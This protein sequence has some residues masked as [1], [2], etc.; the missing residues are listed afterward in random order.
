[1]EGDAGEGAGNDGDGEDDEGDES[2]SEEGDDIVMSGDSADSPGNACCNCAVCRA[3][4]SSGVRRRKY[5]APLSQAW[6]SVCSSTRVAIVLGLTKVL[7]GQFT[8]TTPNLSVM[9]SSKFW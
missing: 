2:G 6:N 1:M 9:W 3:A 7:S 5:V 4:S 8:M